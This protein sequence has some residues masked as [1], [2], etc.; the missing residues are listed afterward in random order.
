MY[1]PSGGAASNLWV[2]GHGFLQASSVTV[3]SRPEPMHFPEAPG[4]RSLTS[5]IEYN[6][7]L[8]YF[9]NLFE[10]DGRIETETRSKGRRQ[11]VV[12]TTGELKDRNWLPGGIGYQLEHTFTDR[13]V[14]RTVRLIYHDAIQTVRIVE[15]IIDYPGMTYTFTNPRTVRIT[16]GDRMFEFALVSGDAELKIGEARG[17]FWAPYPALKAFPIELVVPPPAAGYERKVSYRLTVVR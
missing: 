17:S 14:R 3:Y 8:G 2:G 5:R 12:R 7:S 13:E 10:F 6:D 11:Y 9:T 15:P 16:A 1:R 4:I